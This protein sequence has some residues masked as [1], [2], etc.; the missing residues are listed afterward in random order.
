MQ[1]DKT[2]PLMIIFGPPTK[3]FS[4]F[5]K[6]HPIVYMTPHKSIVHEHKLHVNS[7]EYDLI[8]SLSYKMYTQYH[9]H[10]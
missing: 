8:T 7:Y 6:L 2:N 1:V 5:D 9:K 3:T 10:V 4:L